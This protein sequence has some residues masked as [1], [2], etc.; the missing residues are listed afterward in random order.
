MRVL[1]LGGGGFL[2]Q[3]LAH[4]LMQRGG[5]ALGE[6]DSLTLVDV[7]FPEGMPVDSRLV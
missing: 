7:A 2:G 3:R 6:I 5:L 4:E 1:I